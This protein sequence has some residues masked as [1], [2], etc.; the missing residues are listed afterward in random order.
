MSSLKNYLRSK[1]RFELEL[2]GVRTIVMSSKIFEALENGTVDLNTRI[3]IDGCEGRLRDI[4]ERVIEGESFLFLKNTP[5]EKLILDCARGK[6]PNPAATPAPLPQARAP[7]PTSGSTPLPPAP[8]PR[9]NPPAE[10]SESALPPIDPRP[11]TRD[12]FIIEPLDRKTAY[13]K[14]GI[15]TKIAIF[16]VTVLIVCCAL[17]LLSLLSGG[18]SNESGS[19]K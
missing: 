2:N 6:D 10:Q 17:L 19:A 9:V 8:L 18:T 11:K 7:R 13:Q 14:R 4:D 16:A 5:L 3:W 12:D 15:R 1:Q